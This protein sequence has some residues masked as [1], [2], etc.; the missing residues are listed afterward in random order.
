MTQKQR[1]QKV[2]KKTL[3][4]QKA[5]AGRSNEVKHRKAWRYV[6]ITACVF[7]S[8]NNIV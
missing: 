7:F 8:N 5:W 6:E 4:S 1:G 2:G 3:R